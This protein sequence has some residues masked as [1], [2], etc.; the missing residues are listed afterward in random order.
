MSIYNNK[1][2]N[3]SIKSEKVEPWVHT[4]S[5]LKRIHL[6]HYSSAQP[7]FDDFMYYSIINSAKVHKRFNIS[8]RRITKIMGD[9]Y[10]QDVIRQCAYRSKLV[11][12]EKCTGK[13]NVTWFIPGYLEW[14]IKNEIADYYTPQP[15]STTDRLPA[16]TADRLDTQPASSRHDVH[17]E[18]VREKERIPNKEGKR[19]NTSTSVKKSKVDKPT[20][21][22]YVQH[23]IADLH[24][25]I[26]IKLFP[27]MEGSLYPISEKDYNE[28]GITLGMLRESWGKKEWTKCF[29]NHLSKLTNPTPLDLTLRMVNING[30]DKRKSASSEPDAISNDWIDRRVSCCITMYRE[31]I[32]LTPTEAMKMARRLGIRWTMNRIISDDSSQDA[33]KMATTLLSAAKDHNCIDEII[34]NTILFTPTASE[35]LVGD[36]WLI[37]Y[38]DIVSSSHSSVLVNISHKNE[39]EGRMIADEM[40][41]KLGLMRTL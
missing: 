10:T 14:G 7:A 25:E 28:V 13:W 35:C 27:N 1:N 24:R 38:S 2:E 15:A 17:K 32:K 23:M 30:Y 18:E 36:S 11:K 8:C 6:G 29:T 26:V 21:K 16:S 37:D 19:E 39:V 41:E 34:S 3:T 9:Y 4:E 31:P 12:R 20:S 33:K 22:R 5:I 40:V